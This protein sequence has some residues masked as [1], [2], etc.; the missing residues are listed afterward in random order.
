MFMFMQWRSNKFDSYMRVLYEMLS[1]NKENWLN[2]K[3]KQTNLKD[4][5][6]IILYTIYVFISSKCISIINEPMNNIIN[7]IHT[8]SS[9]EMRKDIFLN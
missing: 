7:F 8:K 6:G 9:F 5:S 2:Y 4:L 3:R 1:S